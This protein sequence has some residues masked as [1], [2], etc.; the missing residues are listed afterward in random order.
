MYVYQRVTIIPRS[1]KHHDFQGEACNFPKKLIARWE[2]LNHP[3]ME[4]SS[5]II[6]IWD[7]GII[8]CA[9]WNTNSIYSE[10]GP[11]YKETSKWVTFQLRLMTSKGIIISDPWGSCGKSLGN[12]YRICIFF[13]KD[14]KCT[15]TKDF[16]KPVQMFVQRFSDMK[17]W[18]NMRYY[19]ILL[20]EYWGFWDHQL[21]HLPSGKLT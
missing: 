2:W 17:Y 3:L 7:F 4:T 20:L 16:K 10:I 18:D 1:K 11:Q 8:S 19:M 13:G 12:T 14:L 21:V 6:Y 5:T 9:I 15:G